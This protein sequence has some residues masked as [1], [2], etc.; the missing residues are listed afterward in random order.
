MTGRGRTVVIAPDSFKGS[1]T[2]AVVGAALAAGWSAQRPCDRVVVLPMADGG[3]GTLDAVE[4]A[5]PG[6]RR[7]VLDATGPDGRVRRATWLQLPASPGLPGGTAVVE[8]AETSGLPPLGGRL[9]P[10]TATTSGLGEAIRAALTAGV[11]RVVVGLGGSASTDGGAG[12]LAALGARLLDDTGAPIGAGAVGLARLA[13]VD[14]AA[15]V[16][17]PPGGVLLLTDVDAPLTGP[18][19]AAA[20]FGPQ[21]GAT[22]ADTD[23][24]DAA[25]T[26]FASMLGLDSSS[27]GS[28]AAGGSAYGLAWWGGRIVPGSG[29]VAELVRLPAAVASADLVI[30]G[31]GRWDGQ[32]VTGKAPAHVA[33]L[34]AAAGVPA[35]LV[36]GRIDAPATGF[37]EALALTDQAPSAS[38]IADPLPFLRAAGAELARRHG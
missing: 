29:A 3:E 37:A 27:P 1:A 34:A 9:L 33:T 24:M 32:S 11:S 23:R 14:R 7:H 12:A 20:V 22:P 30:T 31:E 36:A 10:M 2:S 35:L 38:T 15:L 25:L 6:G 5:V 4:S 19:G 13:R 28:G 21:K 8:L 18:H 17:L 26:A 16:P